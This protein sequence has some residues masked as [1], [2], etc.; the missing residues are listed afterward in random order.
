MDAPSV[1]SLIADIC[2]ILAFIIAILAVATNTIS[3]N[4]RVNS[5][6][7]Q[8]KSNIKQTVTDGDNNKQHISIK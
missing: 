6:S 1:I 2:T 4:V 5:S 3:I 8:E 7:S